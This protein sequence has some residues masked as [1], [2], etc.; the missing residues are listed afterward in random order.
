[1]SGLAALTAT[2]KRGTMN[3]QFESEPYGTVSVDDYG[4]VKVVTLVG[5]H[6]INTAKQV[7][8]QLDASVTA[9]GLVVS[10]AEVEFLDSSIVHALFQADRR[11]RE[12]DRRLVLHVGTPVIVER[13][14]DLSGLKQQMRCTGSL[15]EALALAEQPLE[16][17]VWSTT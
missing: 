16:S 17:T 10:I 1:M 2:L 9:D 12:R 14:L 3:A 15:E 11:L 13:V 7:R 8:A 4:D 6:D 5:E